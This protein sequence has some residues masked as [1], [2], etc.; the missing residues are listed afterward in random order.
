VQVEEIQFAAQLDF[1]RQGRELADDVIEIART[2]HLS[3]V[4]DFIELL[5]IICV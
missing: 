4:F 1:C 2:V 3:P 5:R